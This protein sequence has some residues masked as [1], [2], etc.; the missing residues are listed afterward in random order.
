MSNIQMNGVLR[1]GIL[2]CARIVGRA[3]I[4][5]LRSVPNL[6][7]HG[8]ASRSL[9]RAEQFASKYA[10]PHA[11]GSYEQ[12]LA[13]PDIDVVYIALTN[14]QHVEWVIRSLQ[15]GKHVLVEKPMCLTMNEYE[16]IAAER[17]RSGLDVLEGVMIQHHPWQSTVKRF[18]ESGEY[19][20]LHAVDMNLSVRVD[21]EGTDDYRMYPEQGGGAWYDFGTYWLQTLQAIVGLNMVHAEASSNFDGPN[22]T[23]WNFRAEAMYENGL[24][25]TFKG[26]F[27]EQY[28]ASVVFQFERCKVVLQ[29][30][31]R[32]GIA[33]CKLAIQVE[34]TGSG[35]VESIGY[36][37][38]SYFSNQWQYFSDVIINRISSDAFAQTGERVKVLE[39]LY[40]EARMLS[41]TIVID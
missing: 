13:S 28:E 39:Q 38:Q 22:R 35:D 23:D 2:G 36:E 8:I 33:P 40:N 9:E 10:I 37:K 12:L 18:V 3:L 7:V 14:E 25:S 32:P 1:I 11:F 34:H 24:K 4:Q 27:E 19:G 21:R 16:R 6:T 30:I 26:S 17:L 31:F 15:A 29:D 5:P 20:E 41:T